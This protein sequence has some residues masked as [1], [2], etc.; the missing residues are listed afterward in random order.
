MWRAILEERPDYYKPILCFG[1][2]AEY[3]VKT[4]AVC[5]LASDGEEDIFTI[6]GTNDIM[7]DVEHWMPLPNSPK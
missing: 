2:T 1:Q 6:A 3:S 7:W 5:W 4:M